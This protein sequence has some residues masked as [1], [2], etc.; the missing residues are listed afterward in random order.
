MTLPYFDAE[1]ISKL[2]EYVNNCK[3]NRKT[4]V[5]LCDNN[6]HEKCFPWLEKHIP[7]P[8]IDT[9]ISIA[10][11]EEHKNIDTVT[12]IWKELFNKNV[13]RNTVLFSL[14]GGVVCDLGGFVA[15]SFKRGINN[16]LIPTSLMAQV[17]AAIG[18]KSGFNFEQT[19][20]QIGFFSHADAIFIIPELLNTLPEREILSGFAEMLKHA[21][22][23]DI[24]YWKELSTI[25]SP[26]QIIQS[27]LIKHS[28]DIKTKI[29]CADPYEQNERKKLNFGHTIGHALES[30]FMAGRYSLSHGEAVELGMIA[31]S[32]ISFQKGYISQEELMLITKTLRHFFAI[33]DMNKINTSSL[34]YY[35]LK[36]KKIT[37]KD[38]NF[39]L[40]NSIGNAVINQ[41]V[42]EQEVE[43]AIKYVDLVI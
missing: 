23:A 27:N 9:I 21:L 30:Y 34:F 15:A 11:G 29:C 28:A 12:K 6:T 32:H 33:P 24:L 42:S 40:L 3:A 16:V 36:D 19:K 5:V 7:F 35:L 8:F 1:A 4:V 10:S 25:T 31:E 43:T 41:S 2:G 18:G 13:D 39:T 22:I 38:M 14:G 17:D 20:N 37:G 26:L